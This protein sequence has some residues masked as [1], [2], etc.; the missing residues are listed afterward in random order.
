MASQAA[1][2]DRQS[3]FEINSSSQRSSSSAR[4]TPP[5]A[6]RVEP[7][8]EPIPSSST[9]G[10]FQAPPAVLSQ[11]DD[12]IA[13]QRSLRLFLPHFI[14]EEVTPELTTFGNKVLSKPVLDLVADAEKNLPYL[15]TWD[16]W[17]K[18]RDKLVTSEGWRKLSAIGIEEGTVAIGYENH[19]LQF[20]RPYQFVKYLVWAG[21]S[22]WV[23]C[24]SLMTDGVAALLRKHLSDASLVA[25]NRAVL[26]SAYN[27][28]TSRDPHFAWTT[29]QWMTERQGGSDVSQ[30]ETLARHAP[31][32]SEEEA[33]STGSDGS[34]LGEWLCSGF[35]WFSSATDSSMMVFL[36]RTPNGISTFMAPMRRTIGD[37]KETEL[38]G[39]QIQR[40]KNKL[41]TKALPTA[42][43]VLKD[44][45]AY[46]IGEE[47]RGTKEIALV[48]NIARVHNAMTVIGLWGRGLSI[49]R[50][51]VRVRKVGLK[52]LWSKSAYV[53]TLARLHVEYRANVL[54]C[55]FVASLL[56]IV[57]QPQI[58]EYRK[59][60]DGQEEISRSPQET[61][62]IPDPSAA[63]HIS[64][65][66]APVL[67]GLTAKSAIAGLAECI[68]C[69]GGVGYLESEDMNF[70]IAR[71]YRDANVCSI[72]EGTTDMMAHDVMRVVY[73][74]TSK[75]VMSA[76]DEWVKYATASANPAVGLEAHFVSELWKQW[77][78]VMFD[79]D[80]EEVELR[81]R[82][83]MEK[84]GDVVMGA[85][86]V[87]DAS[88][89]ENRVA[90]DAVRTWT[91][92]RRHSGVPDGW[93][94]IMERDKRVVFG[95]DG[96]DEARARL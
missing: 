91:A 89:D 66:L 39:I 52:P 54:L 49:I 11:L 44:V 65:L 58:A 79:R 34:P 95:E 70:N 80:R 85:L 46:L 38:N 57:E 31:E 1:T 81:S 73:G 36:A 6:T 35:K 84:L 21:S 74:K 72:W 10:F 93:Q 25:Q 24:P 17:G 5:P 86:M 92:A 13:L 77:K 88:Q 42:E 37:S 3:E 68:E 64:R 59:A 87:L 76:M 2:A 53:R 19:Y 41:G 14:R 82:E 71:L 90:V 27:R 56:G 30:T 12:D 75:E 45:R 55:V 22:A 69:M 28:L 33:L 32:L 51:F 40:L 50:A 62:A 8:K 23:T 67:K 60:T 63:E 47:G 61:Y 96:P 29:G 78:E 83:L 4:N 7:Q 26:Q 18:R 20:S 94:Q 9:D 16:S 15:K 43:L 48:L